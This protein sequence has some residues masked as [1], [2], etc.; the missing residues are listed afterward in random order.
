MVKKAQGIE[1][2]GKK[3]SVNIKDLADALEHFKANLL[4]LLIKTCEGELLNFDKKNT[5]SYKSV[6]LE[7]FLCSL[8]PCWVPKT[9]CERN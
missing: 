7:I 1:D 5:C 4:F 9:N 2:E 6:I 8:D 3:M